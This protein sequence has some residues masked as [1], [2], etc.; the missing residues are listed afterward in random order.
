GKNTRD[1][2]FAALQR[3]ETFATSGTRIRLRVFGGWQFK[4]WVFHKRSWIADA[5][6]EGVPM[7]GDLP[8]R[9]NNDAAP[10]F[11]VQGAK[12]P[13]GANLDRIQM[14]KV[15]LHGRHYKEQIFD[16]AVS[17]NRRIDPMSRV[18]PSVGNTVDLT[19]G[20]YS[21]PI[22]VPVL[23]GFWQDPDFSPVEPAVY[24]VRVLEIPTPRWSTL[25]ALKNKLPLSPYVPATIQER[26]WSS[27]IWYTPRC[28]RC[29]VQSARNWGLPIPPADV[30]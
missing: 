18:A 8:R 29:F 19:S 6:A 10:T 4:P 27:P 14:I 20:K 12:D 24:Y 23:T 21:N 28:N 15:S 3:K 1:S 7:G 5:Y 17:G 25:L 2:I 13:T 30:I 22:G 26:A 9:R 11:L 16:V